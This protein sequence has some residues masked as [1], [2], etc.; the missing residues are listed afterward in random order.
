MPTKPA[1]ST[2]TKVRRLKKLDPVLRGLVHLVEQPGQRLGRVELRALLQDLRRSPRQCAADDVVS[3]ALPGARLGGLLVDLLDGVER[4]AFA[5]AGRALGD[6]HRLVAQA[7]RPGRLALLGLHARARRDRRLHQLGGQRVARVGA[8]G[9]LDHLRLGGLVVGRGPH[10][11]ILVGL[12]RGQRQ[13]P[14][15]ARDEPAHLAPFGVVQ[16]TLAG[17]AGEGPAPLFEPKHRLVLGDG[18]GGLQSGGGRALGSPGLEALAHKRGRHGLGRLGAA[19]L[20]LLSRT[21]NACRHVKPPPAPR[22]G[23]WDHYSRRRPQS[24]GPLDLAG[25][26]TLAPRLL[27]A[28]VELLF[29][30]P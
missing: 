24:P 14:D 4:V 9:Q 16:P 26:P 25:A 23:A 10:R 29:G 18:R 22:W 11:P 30:A 6:H 21:P 27:A 2:I 20:G 15:G 13:Q 28:L 8:L 7:A 5:R 19:A 17:K 1:S 12:R 3:D